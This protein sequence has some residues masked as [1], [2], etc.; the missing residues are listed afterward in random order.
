MD[1]PF[2][3]ILGVL[4]CLG[5]ACAAPDAS[6][7]EEGDGTV[8]VAAALSPLAEAAQVIGGD[9]V[10]VVNLTPPGVEPHDLELT[11]R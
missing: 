7:P 8:T 9:C 1:R 5:A 11:P 6:R 4:A 3:A 10:E 2:L